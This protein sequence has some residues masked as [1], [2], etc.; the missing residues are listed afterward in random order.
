MYVSVYI[1][2]YIYVLITITIYVYYPH[3]YIYIITHHPVIVSETSN[4]PT[5]SNT[6]TGPGSSRAFLLLAPLALPAKAA[7]ML[8]R[9]GAMPGTWTMVNPTMGR[10]TATVWLV[11]YLV[12]SDWIQGDTKPFF[13]DIWVCLKMR[14]LP[15]IYGHLGDMMID[16]G[17]LGVAICGQTQSSFLIEHRP[18]TPL[19]SWLRTSISSE[20][21]NSCR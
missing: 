21:S 12:I 16:H 10:Y 4:D 1:Y 7:S 13:F 3:I 9:L 5:W 19:S 15:L 17:I 6:Q 8:P 2:P 14:K 11:I 20:L 18:T